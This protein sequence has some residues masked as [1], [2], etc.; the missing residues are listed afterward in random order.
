M[1]FSIL[2]NPAVVASLLAILSTASGLAANDGPGSLGNLVTQVIRPVM[3]RN[4]IPGMAVGVA[5]RGRG[6]VYNYGLASRAAGSPV[7][8]DTLFEI[9]S[10][11]KTFTATLAAYAQV[12]GRLSL[13]DMASQHLAALRGS[14]FDRVSLLSLGTHTSGG[15][16]LQ[17]PVGITD[18]DRLMAYFRGWK[19][20]FPPGSYR[21]YANPSVGMLGM[22]AAESM[23]GDFIELMQGRIFPLLGLRHTYLEIPDAQLRNYAQG[24]T[25]KDVPIR[26]APGV[27]APETYGVRT[28]AGDLLRFIEANMGMLSLDETLQRAI[29]D[30]HTGYYRI[31]A[32]TQDLIWEQYQYP[33]ELADLLEGNSSKVALE[34][35]PATALIPPLRPQ[36]AVLIN[37]TGSTNGFASYVAFVPQ[38]GIGVVLLANKSYPN[39]ARV[40]AAY[41][42]LKGLN[43][44]VPGN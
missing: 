36:G 8:D 11:S 16:P 27:L 33:A 44:A 42:I 12:T 9:G 39:A 19:P 26:M 23:G 6:S 1:K 17:F 32:M 5:L 4:G 7:T 31:G 20:T 2:L 24:Y 43:K 21:T 35:N 10:V 22:I 38:Q 3:E 14:S 29:N 25:V 18:N 15:F 28:T 30:T 40:K 41:D 34:P 37:K 13:S